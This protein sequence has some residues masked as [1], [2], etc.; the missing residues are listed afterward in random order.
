M[1]RD[2]HSFEVLCAGPAA[3]LHQSRILRK[4][5]VNKF[6]TELSLSYVKVELTW[7][8]LRTKD[9]LHFTVFDTCITC[10]PSYLMVT[11]REW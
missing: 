10:T 8:A 1:C 6:L 11:E 5:C 4:G 9:A 7:A 2:F 3:R